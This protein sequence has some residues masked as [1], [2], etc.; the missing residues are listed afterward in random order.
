MYDNLPAGKIKQKTKNSCPSREN[1]FQGRLRCVPV[2]ARGGDGA[3]PTLPDGLSLEP[4]HGGVV[5]VLDRVVGSEMD[6]IRGTKKTQHVIT[7]KRHCY[8]VTH[9]LV[10]GMATT[11][12]AAATTASTPPLIPAA[13]AAAAND[14]GI[15][16]TTKGRS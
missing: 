3:R 11:A 10:P 9:T 8:F 2:L 16:T 4:P 12:A 6:T 5:T 13:A 7:S 15:N 1:A 14:N